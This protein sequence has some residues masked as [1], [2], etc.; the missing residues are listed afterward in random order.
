MTPTV[1]IE[2]MDGTAVITLHN[3]RIRN[4]LTNGMARQLGALCDEVDHDNNV[5]CLIVTGAEG[6]FCSGAD[7]ATWSGALTD[8][9]TDAALDDADTMYNAF[10]RLGQVRVPTIAA[11]CGAAVGAGLNLALATDLRIVASDARLMAGFVRAGIHPGGGFFTLISRVAG[12]EAA[13]ALGLFSEEISGERAVELGLAWQAVPT[14]DVLD[15]SLQIARRIAKDPVLS[16][17][18][19]R[20]FRLET[21]AGTLPWSAALEVERGVQSWSLARRARSID[22]NGAAQSDP[23]R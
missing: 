8:V 13:A 17:R 5:G 22:A 15:R 6:T 23:A 10:F 7:T 19:S 16:R 4:G 14:D 9:G 21:D 2:Y 11:V 18:V 3:P 1:G 20:S 12:R